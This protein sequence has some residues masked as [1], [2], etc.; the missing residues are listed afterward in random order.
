MLSA[1]V[2]EQLTGTDPAL[3]TIQWGTGQVSAT[4]NFV[5]AIEVGEDDADMSM[6]LR[7]VDMVLL[8]QSGDCLLL[9]DWEGEQILR[10]LWQR[11]AD[12]V[13]CGPWLVNFAYLLLS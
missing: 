9:S 13:T 2:E 10:L 7:P 4:I 1:V 5:R 6:Y 11:P 12:T 8:F 3:N